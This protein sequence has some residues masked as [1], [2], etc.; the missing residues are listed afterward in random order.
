MRTTPM[1][2]ALLTCREFAQL[3]RVESSTAYRW[4]RNGTV[5]SVR[6]GGIVRIPVAELERLTP[7]HLDHRETPP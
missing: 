7:A 1:M 3:L 4:C 6:V 2:P 5:E